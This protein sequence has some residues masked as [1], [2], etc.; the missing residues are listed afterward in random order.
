MWNITFSETNWLR[1]SSWILLSAFSRQ[2]EGQ[3]A[4]NQQMDPFTRRQCKPT[5]VS[6]VRG[7]EGLLALFKNYEQNHKFC[8]NE[9]K[10]LCWCS[11]QR[12]ISPR[13]YSGSL[14]PEVRF[15]VRSRSLKS[16]EEQSGEQNKPW[17][18]K[19]SPELCFT[20]KAELNHKLLTWTPKTLHLFIN[21][22]VIVFFI[23]FFSPDEH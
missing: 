1:C 10:F 6:N 18:P 22:I 4:K 11:G 17:D 13:S 14:E 12:S 16:W 2:A 19:L 7:L 5:M 23:V 15:W 8:R 21:L 9:P 3:N 20:L